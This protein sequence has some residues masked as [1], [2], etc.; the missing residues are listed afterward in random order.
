MDEASVRPLRLCLAIIAAIAV[1][2]NTR[3]R[4]GTTSPTLPVTPSAEAP[5][6]GPVAAK[7]V[8]GA[9]DS[10][11]FFS[12]DDAEARAGFHIPVPDAYYPM[13]FGRTYV[14]RVQD[15]TG[16][17]STTQYTYPPLAPHSIGVDAGPAAVF[18]VSDFEQ[19]ASRVLGSRGGWLVRNDNTAIQFAFEYGETDGTA[20]WCVVLAPAE[21][22][23]TR[24][25]RLLRRFTRPGLRNPQR[26]RSRVTR[27]S[28]P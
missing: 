22:G 23:M 26:R 24:S 17:L 4:N 11:E 18:N 9:L 28:V 8:I 13:A 14:Q 15:G 7:T 25:R 10:A 3:H 5:T 12:I 19:K 21:I 16:T 2:C 20:L 1:G 6:V 27:G